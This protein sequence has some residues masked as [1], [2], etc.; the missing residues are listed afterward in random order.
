ME[1]TR[2]TASH[3]ETDLQRINEFCLPRQNNRTNTRTIRPERCGYGILT[4]IPPN[5]KWIRVLQQIQ[6][7]IFREE[8]LS[9]GRL[10]DR[11]HDKYPDWIVDPN[12][13]AIAA[14]LYDQECSG[15]QIEEVGVTEFNG[16]FPQINGVQMGPVIL[17]LF[18]HMLLV[19]YGI[20]VYQ[21]QAPGPIPRWVFLRYLWPEFPSLCRYLTEFAGQCKQGRLP[22]RKGWE[23]LMWRLGIVHS[24]ELPD[25]AIMVY[26][27]A[28]H[29]RQLNYED[30]IKGITGYTGV[31]QELIAEV[32]TRGTD[33]LQRKL[34]VDVNEFIPIYVRDRGWR[35]SMIAKAE[36][37]AAEYD[38]SIYA[39]NTNDRLRRKGW[40]EKLGDFFSPADVDSSDKEP[41]NMSS[42]EKLKD[43]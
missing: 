19:D 9:L 43:D 6:V 27:Y 40:M 39:P 4:H 34:S 8:G 5:E 28:T 3:S 11:P 14:I 23:Y 30:Y 33:R 42:K 35:E 32:P 36:D 18:E 41:L 22:D 21:L 17:P 25:F 16:T 15:Q 12:L 20:G 13:Q 7:N 26:Y 24:C 2:T 37:I 10:P 1:A 31:L 38:I 29:S